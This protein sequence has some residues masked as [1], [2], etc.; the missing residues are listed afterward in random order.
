MV[1]NSDKQLKISSL[2]DLMTFKTELVKV[3]KKSKVSFPCVEHMMLKPI[4]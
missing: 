3:K 1:R 2:Q 4:F